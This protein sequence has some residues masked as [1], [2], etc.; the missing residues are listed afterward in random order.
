M[1]LS[2]LQNPIKAVVQEELPKMFPSSSLQVAALSDVIR[3]EVQ[4]ALG[5]GS[6]VKPHQ[7]PE[8]TARPPKVMSYATA[9]QS[10]V[11][12]TRSAYSPLQR[13]RPNDRPP[14]VEQAAPRKSDVWRTPDQRPL[15]F[16]CDEP[17]HVYRRCF[18]RNLGVHG[19]PIGAPHPQTGQRPLEIEHYLQRQNSS[20]SRYWSPSTSSRRFTS[21]RPSY[22]EAARGRS[23][24]PGLGN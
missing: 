20:T 21:P 24:S 12:P 17:G 3:Q 19:F 4:Q 15:C 18:Y 16:H 5:T 10:Q 14:R 9:E 8:Y 7:A 13:S 23:P 6:L 11:R 22:A 1:S 2:N